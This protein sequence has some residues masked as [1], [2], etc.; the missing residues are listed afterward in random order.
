MDVFDPHDTKIVSRMFFEGKGG[1]EIKFPVPRA[2]DY[3]VCFNNEMARWTAKVKR[4]RE[5]E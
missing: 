2:G 1:H 3:Q 4:E 5:K